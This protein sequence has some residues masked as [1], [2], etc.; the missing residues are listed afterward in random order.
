MLRFLD[1]VRDH[2]SKMVEELGDKWSGDE[3]GPPIVVHCSSGIGS[4]M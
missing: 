2:Q 3:N 4:G 1:N